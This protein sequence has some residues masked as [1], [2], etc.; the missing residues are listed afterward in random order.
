[1]SGFS[2]SVLVKLFEF[3]DKLSVILLKLPPETYLDSSWP[4]VKLE[5][6]SAVVSI[7]VELLPFET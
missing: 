7:M 5:L 2:V 6:L 4:F 3:N 1:M